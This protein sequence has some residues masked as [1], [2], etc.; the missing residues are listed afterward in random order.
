MS[1]SF[2]PF[3]SRFFIFYLPLLFSLCVHEWAH[4]RI[5][6]MKGDTLAASEGRLSLN[7]AVHIDWIGTVF[8]PLISIF[9]GLPV[10]WL[11]KTGPGERT[12]T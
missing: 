11:G 7:P 9:T 5:A 6:L 10:F 4:A 2:Y 12:G 1:D 3:I 8:L